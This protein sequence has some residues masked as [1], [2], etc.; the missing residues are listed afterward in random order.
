MLPMAHTPKGIGCQRPMLPTSNG[1]IYFY[2]TA[3]S[4]TSTILITELSLDDTYENESAENTHLKVYN[5]L[6]EYGYEESIENHDYPEHQEDDEMIISNT[7]DG[8]SDKSI[9]QDE[10]LEDLAIEDDAQAGVIL[11]NLKENI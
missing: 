6:N 2:C 8:R 1:L 5:D 4:S 10:Y 9:Y 11:S 3:I 7:T